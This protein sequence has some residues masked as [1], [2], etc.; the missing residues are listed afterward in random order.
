[1]KEKLQQ[2]QVI[3]KDISNGIREGDFFEMNLEKVFSSV[4]PDSRVWVLGAGKAAV[5]MAGLTEAYFGTSIEDGLLIAPEKATELDR[6]QVFQGTHPYPDQDSVSASMEMW[7]LAK[8]IPVEDTVIFCLSGGASSLFCIP[9]GNIEVPDMKR[10]YELLLKSGATIEEVNCVRKHLSD[11]TGGK[12]GKVL[13]SHRVLS[14]ILSDVPGDDP[15]IIGSAPTVADPSTFKEAFQILKKYR[16][17]EDTPHVIRVHLTKGMHGGAEE[18]PKP[19]DVDWPHHK[20]HVVSGASLLANNISELL[21]KKGYR[22]K[23]TSEAY[24]M[25]VQ[26]L[27]KQICSEAISV[28]SEKSKKKQPTALIY[29]GE[30]TVQ[31]QGEGKGGRNQE[32]AL[33]AAISME[34]QH[35]I[36]LLSYAT[37]GIDGPTDAAGALVNSQTSLAARKKKLNPE[38]Y[39]QNNDSYHF[40]EEMDSLIKTGATGNNLMDLQV[41]L[42]H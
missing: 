21:Q 19:E 34:G 6:I 39:L 36:S 42:I 17:W 22:T 14:V 18:N 35:P 11:H 20:V 32:L 7:E 26:K 10:M 24:N 5:D 23:V 9:S 28:L 8:K 27:S 33:H 3:L 30:S 29:Y 38:D 41:V 37:D 4:D 12:L 13:G 2:Q 16:L 40:H 1:M 15:S 25:S 31:V